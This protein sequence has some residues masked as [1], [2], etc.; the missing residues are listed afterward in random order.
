MEDDA[1][2]G[3]ECNFN[4]PWTV[5]S[6]ETTWAEDALTLNEKKLTVDD[7]ASFAAAK[8]SELESFFDNQVWTFVDAADAPVGRTLRARFI[9]KWSTNEDGTPRAKARLVVQGLRDP[10]ALE[11]RL[12]TSSPTATRLSRH[13]VLAL[14]AIYKW[15]PWTADV[16]T[17][18]LQGKPKDREL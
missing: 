11:G 7:R 3:T 16:A 1:L 18:F 5:D 6:G 2:F 4:G 17:A 15:M 12:E 14:A 13:V 8:R 10:D 9:L